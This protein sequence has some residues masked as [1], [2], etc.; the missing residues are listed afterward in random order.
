MIYHSIYDAAVYF[1]GNILRIVIVILSN[2]FI[3]CS[4]QNIRPV[5][6]SNNKYII[7]Y[8][9]PQDR[10]ITENEIAVEKLTHINYAFADIRGGEIAEGFKYDS[11]NLK[12]LNE[13]KN[14]N[15][16]LKIL[17]SVGGWA[18]GKKNSQFIQVFKT[19]SGKS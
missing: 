12:I 13:T 11:V 18:C 17:I 9:F 5:Q 7:A 19:E 16:K 6:P 1:G 3:I 2:V 8:F 4:C 15:P 10:I 14:R